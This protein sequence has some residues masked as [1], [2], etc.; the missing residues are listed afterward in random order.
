M[1]SKWVRRKDQTVH[2]GIAFISI[3]LILK[4]ERMKKAEMFLVQGFV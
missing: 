3:N 4:E 1:R 2:F